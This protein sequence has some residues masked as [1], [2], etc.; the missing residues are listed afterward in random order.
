MIGDSYFDDNSHFTSNE[1][2]DP[3]HTILYTQFHPLEGPKL[4]FEFPP[5]NLKDN[6][7]NFQD[8]QNY[9]IPKPQLCKKLLTLIYKDFR[10]ISFPMYLKKPYYFRNV[11]CFNF[12]F[13]FKND[14]KTVPYE[15]IIEKLG[16]M[17]QIL[18][19]QSQILS[20]S[21]KD[22][23]YFKSDEQHENID[24]ITNENNSK[25]LVTKLYLDLNNYS[26]CLIPINSGDSID[27]KLFT[28]LSKSVKT[29]NSL[30]LEDVPLLKL[31][32]S[33]INMFKKLN[34]D[35]TLLKM[36]PYINGVN[37]I[38]KISHL[39]N[40]DLDLVVE[41]IKN[42][43][44]IYKICVIV[45]IFQFDNIYGVTNRLDSVFLK[46]PLLL[47]ECQ[48]YIV[49]DKVNKNSEVLLPSKKIIFQLY[50]SFK[51]TIR[52]K[53]FYKENYHYIV[54]NNI[55]LRKFVVFGCSNNIIYR[56]MEYPLMRD[57]T[58]L[59]GSNLGG[60]TD[61]EYKSFDFKTRASKLKALMSNKNSLFST[62]DIKL[63]EKEDNTKDESTEVD[64]LIAPKIESLSSIKKTLKK[65]IICLQ[66]V[67]NLDRICVILEKD[68]S[69]V[70]DVLAEIGE[71]DTVNM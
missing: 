35:Q 2:I 26:E 60:F 29:L 56:V 71:Y 21:C 5:N 46:N 12:V 25:S 33:S 15:P 44:Y 51:L 11:F 55:D 48:K 40:S 69:Y 58:L 9:I 31:D 57:I 50:N 17:F 65:L 22:M 36:L 52:V 41:V 63:T 61:E 53:Q 38:Y 23:I 24:E 43:V 6:N 14:S 34:W 54:K 64:Q 32:L 39:A 47:T 67:D 19:E 30:S 70:L 62:G 66:N 1:N 18:E 42:L 28:F 16:K 68:K 45:D 37:N 7:I 59:Y 27:I 3:I 20:M 8:I 10:L 13:I 4:I 49:V